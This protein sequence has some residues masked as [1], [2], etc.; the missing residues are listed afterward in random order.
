MNTKVVI[1]VGVGVVLI[2][3][4]VLF[5]KVKEP[6]V[7]APVVET[8]SAQVSEVPSAPVWLTSVDEHTG[9]S[10]KYP[11]ELNTTYLHVQDWPPQV[12]VLPWAFSCND[13]ELRVVNGRSYCVST[14][15][16]G[17]AGST[18][19]SYTYAFAHGQSTRIMT[20][21]LRAVQCANYDE[22]KRSE[23]EEER[24]V[25]N[26]DAVVDSIAQSIVVK[27]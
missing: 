12:R 5:F 27:Q 7:V 22:P 25:F 18:Y 11:K 16:E 26:L 10:L 4:G 13:A 8:P 23:C 1:A 6:A 3:L 17:A 20:F 14:A 2:V 19:T 24:T 15:G 9:V 21:S